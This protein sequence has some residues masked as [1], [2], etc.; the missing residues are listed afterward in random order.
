MR[1]WSGLTGSALTAGDVIVI[2]LPGDEV[3]ALQGHGSPL[4]G[5]LLTAAVLLM[6]LDVAAY[7]H[8]V[9]VD[10]TNS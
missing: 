9:G 2:V 3:E 5:P 4:P 7:R 6:N 10:H 1:Y 8:A